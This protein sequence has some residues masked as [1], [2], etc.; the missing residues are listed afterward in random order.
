MF[1]VV[2]AR[3]TSRCEEELRRARSIRLFEGSVRAFDLEARRAA[4]S[5]YAVFT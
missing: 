3:A 4:N 1:P 5:A 2:A